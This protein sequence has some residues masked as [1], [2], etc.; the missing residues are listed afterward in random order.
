MRHPSHA[1]PFLLESVDL[2]RL[3][4]ESFLNRNEISATRILLIAGRRRSRQIAE[5]LARNVAKLETRVIDCAENSLALHER[6]CREDLT[7]PGQTLVAGVGGAAVLDFAK[8]HASERG[9]DY[10]AVPVSLSSDSLASPTATLDVGG[11][12]FEDR[13]TRLP[14]G[15]LIDRDTLAKS[16]T[17]TL[18]NGLGEVLSN[19]SAVLDWD[20]AVR[21]GRGKPNAL[22]RL[23]SQSA[24]QGILG[25]SPQLRDD[26]FR[27]RYLNAI[28]LSGLAKYV[29]GSDCPCDGSEHLI[30]KV[31]MRGHGARY[32]H[33]FLVGSVAPYIAWLHDST[34]RVLVP[35]ARAAGFRFAFFDLIRRRRTFASLIDE[36]RRCG[37]DRHTVLDHYSDSELQVR[38]FDFLR[39]IRRQPETATPPPHPAAIRG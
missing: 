9:F 25:A 32:G 29:G 14:L 21:E 12:I 28:L 33:G 27:E 4:L 6:I 8:Y 30:A 19:H 20:L 26:H 2:A 39:C 35:T 1:F 31:I 38:Y 3:D 11:G 13:P 36:A 24:V 37:G 10:V 17:S 7:G 22:A 23:F 15:V 34:D 5:V 18:K 16:P